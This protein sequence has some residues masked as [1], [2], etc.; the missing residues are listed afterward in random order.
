VTLAAVL[1]LAVLPGRAGLEREEVL[2]RSVRIA[3]CLTND[4]EALL[5]GIR[6]Y[7]NGRPGKE[8]GYQTDNRW[9]VAG[10]P[11]VPVD[12][13]QY[14]KAAAAMLQCLQAFVLRDEWNRR[15]FVRYFARRYHGGGLGQTDLE[16]EA[17]DRQYAKTLLAVFMRER[18]ALLRRRPAG[19]WSPFDQAELEQAACEAAARKAR[20]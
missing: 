9:A 12:G 17:N 16:R 13:I 7:E 19:Q 14:G 18:D 4:G 15:Q 5:R 11:L 3:Y 8:C 1:L 20:K 6:A 10:N 2:I